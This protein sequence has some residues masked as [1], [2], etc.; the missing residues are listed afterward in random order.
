MDQSRSTQVISYGRP[1][2]RISSAIYFGLQVYSP[3]IA[4]IT[5]DR[6]STLV[7]RAILRF[8]TFASLA[9]TRAASVL[10]TNSRD[11][12]TMSWALRM[13]ISTRR[14]GAPRIL[15]TRF[16]SINLLT[17]SPLA[18]LVQ[19]AGEVVSSAFTKVGSPGNVRLGQFVAHKQCRDL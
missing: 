14:N 5:I 1:L 8:P 9:S 16:P 15:V 12:R 3:C 7:S 10:C 18:D 6:L 11:P 17:R 13:T 4:S 19:K 2:R